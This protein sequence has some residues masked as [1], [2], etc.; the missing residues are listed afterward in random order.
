M[1]VTPNSESESKS[2]SIAQ[3]FMQRLR[4]AEATHEVKN[5]AALFTEDAELEN[6]TRPALHSPRKG[7]VQH[8]SET[9]ADAQ[10]FWRQYLSAFERIESH[11]TKVTDDG[12]TAVMEWHSDGRMQMGLE[13]DYN[14]VSIIEYDGDRIHRFRTY[15]DSAALLPHAPRTGQSYSHSVGAPEI[16]NEASS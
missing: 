3:T 9:R 1:N 6:L 12:Q 7:G 10:G 15:Y 11:F 13:V 4:E 5:L 8:S 16:T 2:Q 14:G